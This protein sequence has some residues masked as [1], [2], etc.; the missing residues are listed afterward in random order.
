[1]GAFT[2]F[3]FLPRYS[4]IDSL[5]LYTVAV[6]CIIKESFPKRRIFMELRQLKS[7]AAERVAASRYNANKLALLFTGAQVAMSFLITLVNFLLSRQIEGTGGLGGLGT[8]TILTAAQM[9]LLV[10]GTLVTPFWNLGYTRA[11]L[12]TVRRGD[13]EPRTLL[14]GFR[15][16]LPALRLF[17]LQAALISVAFF[18][19]VQA[20]T[21]LYMLTPISEAAMQLIESL[22]AGGEAALTAPGA[23][24][25]LIS[26]FWPMYLLIGVAL[27]VTMLPLLYRLRLVEFSLVDGEEKALKNLAWSNHRM[28]GKCFWMFKLDLSFWWFFLL[29]GLAA[30]LAY[31]DLLFGGGDVTYWIFYV[32]SAG[33]QL[34]IGWAF[35]PKVQA[36]YALAYEEITTDTE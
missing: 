7:L 19:A 13:A 4:K 27:L 31:G 17:F 3:A 11:A 20:G 36:T 21:I 26:V 30:V 15:L 32:L 22:L 14:E 2:F 33:A 6:S 16:F 5:H 12:N 9:L 23:I 18:V 25:Q 10:F 24:D 34:A 28:R 8:R 35:F 29:Q 1:M